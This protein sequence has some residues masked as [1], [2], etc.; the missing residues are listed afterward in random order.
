MYD[1]TVGWQYCECAS[2]SLTRLACPGD[3]VQMKARKS[4]DTEA[5]PLKVGPWFSRGVAA[6][7]VSNAQCL[8]KWLSKSRAHPLPACCH[9]ALQRNWRYEDQLAYNAWAAAHP[10]E[11]SID[12]VRMPCWLCC[13]AGSSLRM[14]AML[15]GHRQQMGPVRACPAADAL[16][17]MLPPPFQEWEPADVIATGSGSQG[18]LFL[19]S[20][21]GWCEQGSV[22]AVRG[23]G[24]R[25]PAVG[26]RMAAL[27]VR[28]RGSTATPPACL[29]PLPR[30]LL[31]W[32]H[33]EDEAALHSWHTGEDLRRYGWRPAMLQ[34][35]VAGK[36][37]RG[38][39]ARM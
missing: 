6:R 37:D 2:S 5:A 10:T 19:V 29:P 32:L 38:M 14:P 1:A 9:T 31:P 39:V 18:A 33:R 8:S 22:R 20:W 28:S 24:V 25:Q 12:A 35:R 16:A 17:L 7:L 30:L 11:A 23:Q 15:D 4:R 26:P 21:K 3:L 13:T 36:P 27:A 34:Q